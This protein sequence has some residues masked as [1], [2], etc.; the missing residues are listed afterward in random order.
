MHRNTL[1][2]RLERIEEITGLSFDNYLDL[3]QFL[4]A[5]IVSQLK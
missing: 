3:F 2:Y 5:Y 4:I 1:N